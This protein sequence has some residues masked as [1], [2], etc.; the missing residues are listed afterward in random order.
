MTQ[1]LHL[2]GVTLAPETIIAR[3]SFWTVA[4]NHNQNLL[5]FLPI[6]VYCLQDGCCCFTRLRSGSL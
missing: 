2:G 3:G 4:L 5:G 1:E 6:V